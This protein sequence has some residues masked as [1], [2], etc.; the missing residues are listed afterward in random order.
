MK[1]IGFIGLG[2]MG[3]A[4][5]RAILKSSS[6]AI[7]ITVTSRTTA[8]LN[9]FKKE[10]PTIAIEEKNAEVAMKSDLLFICVN[11]YEVINV[12]EEIGRHLGA[13]T[14]IISIAGG[15]TIESFENKFKGKIS[16]VIPTLTCEVLE[17]TSLVCHNRNVNDD[18][19]AYLE[20]M[21]GKIGSVME[22]RE[23][24]FPV[25]TALSSCAPGLIASIFD[26]LLESASKSG[27][28]DKKKALQ[29]VLSS[30]QGT[31]KIVREKNE[32]FSSLIDRV[33]RKG[34]NTEIGVTLFRNNFPEVFDSMFSSMLANEK[35]RNIKTAEQFKL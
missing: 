5:L 18:E 3:Q 30:L 1:K 25:Y 17:G 11:T 4:L 29:I 34:G 28:I 21:L 12:L 15:L 7:S 32:S 13:N 20:N 26:L 23:D 10:F 8:K 19:R 22:I 6:P 27:D 33:A 2:H 31:S 35:R 9:E 16:K 14:H 24:Q